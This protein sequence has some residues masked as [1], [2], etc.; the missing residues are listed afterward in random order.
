MRV[1][2]VDDVLAWCWTHPLA[3]AA[4]VVVTTIVGL[5]IVFRLPK[6]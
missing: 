5:V 4:I 1:G 6:D 3:F 2:I